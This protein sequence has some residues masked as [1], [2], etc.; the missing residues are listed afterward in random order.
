LG[1]QD[2]GLRALDR[3]SVIANA[4]PRSLRHGSGREMSVSM[5][6]GMPETRLS[7][8]RTKWKCRKQQQLDILVFGMPKIYS[9]FFC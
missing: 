1:L 7:S 2:Y 4:G 9:V 5:A 8:H 6:F 3:H